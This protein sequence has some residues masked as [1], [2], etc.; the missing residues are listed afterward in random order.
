MSQKNAKYQSLPE[1]S[2]YVLKE[3]FNREKEDHK[4]MLQKIEQLIDTSQEVTLCDAGCGSGEFLYFIKKRYP[5]WKLTG[6][7]YTKEFIDTG[8][9]FEGLEGI[10]LIHKDIYDIDETFDIVVSDGVTQIFPDM[11]KI[12][13]KKLDMC[14]PGGYV[15]STGRF[16]KFDIEVRLQ[17]CDNSNPVAKGNWRADWNQHSRQSVI[18]FFGDKVKSIEFVDVVMDKDLPLNEDFPINQ[19]TFRDANGKNIITNGT[20]MILNKTLLIMQ[21]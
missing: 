19:F 1:L 2:P 12:L 15:V 14:N 9:S 8:K 16:N 11:E 17:Y 7:D 18:R 3:R 6:Y 5:H 10:R 13:Q 20:N 4:F 21:K